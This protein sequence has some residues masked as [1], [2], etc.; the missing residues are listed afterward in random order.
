MRGFS[1]P[2]HLKRPID[3][4]KQR[5]AERFEAA[6]RVANDRAIAIQIDS[7]SR[8]NDGLYRPK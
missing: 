4:L 5:P 7:D 1:E 6:L 3:N 2:R 8:N